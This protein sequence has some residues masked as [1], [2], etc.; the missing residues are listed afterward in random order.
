MVESFWMK[1]A[2]GAASTQGAALPPIKRMRPG[3]SRMRLL[4]GGKEVT[5]IH[6]FRI[7]ARVTETDAVEEGFY[8]FDPAAIGPTCGTVSVVLS[9]VKDPTKTETRTVDPAIVRRVWD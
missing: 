5:P 7:Q 1:L 2:R 8:A 4:C 3:F 6:P 9:S